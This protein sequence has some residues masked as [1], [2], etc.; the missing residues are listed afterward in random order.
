VIQVNIFP[1]HFNKTW[2]GRVYLRSEQ[3]GKDFIV[4][5]VSKRESLIKCYKSK[6]H[7][8]FNINVDLKTLRR[9]KQAERKANDIAKGIKNSE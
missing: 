8:S 3:D 1:V 2:I 7:I 5:Y 9:I 6:D 4:D